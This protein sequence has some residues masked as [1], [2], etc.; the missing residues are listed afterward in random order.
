MP[1]SPSTDD[2]RIL[3]S[4][5]GTD[6]DRAEFI[7][8]RVAGKLI[9]VPGPGWYSYNGTHWV[10]DPSREGAV[11]RRMAHEVSQE[12]VSIAQNGGSNDFLDAGRA[13]RTSRNISNALQELKAMPA[14]RR[15][16]ND[17]DKD[18][19]ALNFRNGTVDLRTGELRAHNADDLI[20]YVVEYD[21]RPDANSKRWNSFLESVQPGDAEVQEFL[22]RAIGYGLTASTREERLLFF[23]GEG[24]NG[25]GVLTETLHHIFGPVTTS[26]QR[27]FWE[28]S[29]HGRSGALIAKLHGARM[30]FSSEMTTARLDEAFV[31][32]YTAADTLSANPKYAQPYDFKPVGLLVLSGNDKP[33]ITGTDDGIWRRFKCV[34]WDESF[35][36]RRDDKLKEDLQSPEHAEA[37]IAWSVSGAVTWFREGLN[38]PARVTQATENYREESDPFRDWVEAHFVADP[39]GFVPNAEI[40]RRGE[41]ATP[42]LP[43]T[44]K[45]WVKAIARHFGTTPGKATVNGKQVRGIPG[46][47]AGETDIFGQ[48]R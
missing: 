27:D 37:I 7:T 5:Q 36:D 40:K 46:V 20:T 24:E 22:R 4:Q 42:R 11:A 23:Y 33:T 28:A 29:K 34:P 25:K 15:E 45:L 26:Q 19:F 18:E 14:I 2:V 44:V 10:N 1:S 17:L 9:Y 43:G 41:S 39:N 3:T 6:V 16:V 47:R 48:S 38:E 12:L 35:K 8:S 21:Y 13:L 32:A 31:K 30:V